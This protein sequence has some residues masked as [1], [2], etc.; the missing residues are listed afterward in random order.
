M[1]LET[2]PLSTTILGDHSCLSVASSKNDAPFDND[3]D[4]RKYWTQ[5]WAFWHSSY[6][7]TLN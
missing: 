7:Q 2:Q 5:N 4:S 1:S 3:D 6:F